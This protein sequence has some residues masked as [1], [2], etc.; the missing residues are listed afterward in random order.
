[1]SA[2]L[3]SGSSGGAPPRSHLVGTGGGVT[4]RQRAVL[5]QPFALGGFK[6]RAEHEEQREG[7][8]R[9]RPQ[10]RPISST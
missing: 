8:K 7:G 6:L 4:L 3:T 1:M 2:P 10:Q 5:A 9:R